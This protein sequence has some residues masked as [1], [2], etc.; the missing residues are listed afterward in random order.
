MKYDIFYCLIESGRVFMLGANNW[1]QLGLG[2]DSIV[3]KPF[4][5]KGI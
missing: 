1:G 5:V 4:C 2:H 3:N